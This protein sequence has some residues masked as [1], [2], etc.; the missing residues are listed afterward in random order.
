[1]KELNNQILTGNPKVDPYLITATSLFHEFG[2]TEETNYYIY[3]FYEILN[4]EIA[5]KE[6]FQDVLNHYYPEGFEATLRNFYLS[7]PVYPMSLERSF[8]INAHGTFL[9]IYNVAD[10]LIRN[11]TWTE[12]IIS[13]L[14]NYE[15]YFE[16]EDFKELLDLIED[17]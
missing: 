3:Y 10:V 11:H 5:N 1:M 6:E 8:D 12:E 2:G 16:F 15:S 14:Y 7:D 4:K 17:I 13:F 9:T